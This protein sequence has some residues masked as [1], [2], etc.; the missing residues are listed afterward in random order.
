MRQFFTL[1]RKRFTSSSPV[2]KPSFK[3]EAPVTDTKHI[4]DQRNPFLKLPAELLLLIANLLDREYQ[5]LLSLSCRQLRVLLDSS[6]DLSL[7]DASVKVRFSQCL[8]LDYPEYLTCRSCGYMFK[9]QARR[10]FDYRCPRFYDHP[11]PDRNIV[12]T[13]WMHQHKTIVVTREIVDLIL[14]AHE[15]GQ[16]YGLHWSFL[17][18]RGTDDDGIP[19]ENEAR[20]VDRQLLLA[21]RWEAESDS[22]QGIVVKGRGFETAVCLHSGANVWREKLW[23][24]VE[25]AVAGLTDAEEPR[26]FKCP[27]C[28]TDYNLR[29]ENG[30]GGRIRLVLDVWRNYGRLYEKTL[31][32]EQIFQAHYSSRTDA[33]ALSRRD[34]RALFESYGGK[35]DRVGVC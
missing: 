34:L 9:W 15:R 30:P 4:Q 24:T 23:Q 16:R 21:S 5:V 13:W 26:V 8:E 25:Q 11:R 14:R 3:V 27:F 28:A 1:V 18:T 6:L 10:R 17:S 2:G 12:Y 31:E 7:S 35:T 19:R 29:V 20:L 22:G 32:S 33:D